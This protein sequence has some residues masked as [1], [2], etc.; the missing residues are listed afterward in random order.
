MRSIVSAA[1]A[2]LT[3]AAM[4]GGADAGA[5]SIERGAYLAQ[6]MDCAGCHSG[7]TA[8]GAPDPAQFLTGGPAG[9]EIPGLGVFWPPNLTPDESG[10]GAWSADEIVHA[11]RTGERPDGR[12]LA[13]IMP[14]GSYAV[15]SDA[16]AADLAA[17]LKSLPPVAN[18]VP[19]P[20][21]SAE[22]ARA[23]YFTM[24]VWQ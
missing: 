4:A 5:P 17:Y 23:P 21:G 7:R 12:M 16:D 15:L 8:E 6:I 18:K 24:V 20:V 19:E 11:I 14:Y 22:S 2:G 3:A 10:L 13:P 9:F 1:L